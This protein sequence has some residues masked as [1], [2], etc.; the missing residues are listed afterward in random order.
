MPRIARRVLSPG[1]HADL[2]AACAAAAA[3]YCPSLPPGGGGVFA[4]LYARSDRVDATC[5]AAARAA[6]GR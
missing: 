6:V 3:R 1:F 2:P 4:C 5:S